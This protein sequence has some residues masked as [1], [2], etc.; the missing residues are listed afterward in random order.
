MKKWVDAVNFLKSEGFK[1][2]SI[3]DLLDEIRGIGLHQSRAIEA[4]LFDYLDQ[5]IISENRDIIIPMNLY[6]R[7]SKSCQNSINKIIYSL[8]EEKHRLNIND[9]ESGH[10]YEI[11]TDKPLYFKEALGED[12][13][14]AFNLEFTKNPE[15][16][17]FRVLFDTHHYIFKNGCSYLLTHEYEILNHD[18]IALYQKLNCSLMV[19]VSLGSSVGSRMKL[20]IETKLPLL[21]ELF[22]ETN[23][24]D[25]FY[26]SDQLSVELKEKSKNANFQEGG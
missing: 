15:E 26:Y 17:N 23:F 11:F 20:A 22:E 3:V 21:C 2:D 6:V 12:L 14:K 8:L 13:L 5:V 25:R 7:P 16:S 10:P 1:D 9:F 24:L 4:V 19:V 18:E